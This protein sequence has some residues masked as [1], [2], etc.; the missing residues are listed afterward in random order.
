MRFVF[1]LFVPIAVAFGGL[2][3]Y[4]DWNAGPPIVLPA[5]S[6]LAVSVANSSLLPGN[7]TSS[8]S[9]TLSATAPPHETS[10][11]DVEVR[12]SGQTFSNVP[13]AS[14]SQ[15][16]ALVACK[17]AGCGV[18]RPSVTVHLADGRYQWQ[19]RY[20]NG[21]GIGPWI[22]YPGWINVDTTPPDAPQITSSTDPDPH[23]TYHSST[24]AFDWKST[25]AGSGLAGYSYRLDTNPRG[26][27]VPDIR[28]SRG[29]IT[30][31]GLNTGTYY[32][33][34]RARDNAGN[35][36]STATFPVHIDVTPPGLAHVRFSLYQFDPL[37]DNLQVSFAVTRPAQTIRV[38][39]YRQSDGEL[40]RLYHFSD[41][42]KGQDVS[43]SWDGR[44]SQGHGVPAGD[45]MVYVRAIDKYGH[46]S[47]AGWRDFVVNYQ[48]IVVSLHQQK[49]WAY[50]GNTTF[51]TSLVTSGNPK[52]PTPTGTF[53]VMGLFHPFTFISPWPKSSPFYYPPS[54]VQYAMLFR[55]G[56]YFIHDA[57]W[58]SVFGPGSNQ[59]IGTPGQNYTG[60]HGCINVPPDV[61]QRLYNW[62]KIGTVVQVEP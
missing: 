50:D 27:A 11:L 1:A 39:V 4:R 6:H 61:A 22:T 49:L 9:I 45:Y 57:P 47:L 16:T 23:R 48:R 34:A 3:A 25:D 17:T 21:R 32:F 30:L 14:A 5:P 38:G 42:P 60:T 19:V 62:V 15:A 31:A 37:Y 26:E 29:T 43:V 20:H 51:L 24:L 10:G 12:P 7:W 8:G 18:P 40:L 13:T 44:D 41:V 36:G 2:L 55:D 46:S 52:L 59:Q 56:G 28:T 54:K 53:H 58:R 35:W 33:H